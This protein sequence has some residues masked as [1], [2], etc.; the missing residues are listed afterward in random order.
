MAERHW[1]FRATQTED[2]VRV[3]WTVKALGHERDKPLIQTI[4]EELESRRYDMPLLDFEILPVWNDSIQTHNVR[5]Y[6]GKVW[7][8][9]RY[10]LGSWASA[11]EFVMSRLIELQGDRV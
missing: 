1:T 6:L 5:I 4:K 3:Y 8:E 10:G 11:E 7:Q 9:V 2:L